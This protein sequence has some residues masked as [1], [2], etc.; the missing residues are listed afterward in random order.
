MDT[1]ITLPDRLRALFVLFVALLISACA[2]RQPAEQP[3]VIHEGV[4]TGGS[5]V[6]FSRSGEMLASG[7]WEGAIHLW[8]MPGGEPA[9]HWQAHRDSVN[10]VAFSADGQ[11][12]VSAGYDKQL[13]AWTVNGKAV[14]RVV[15]PSPVTHMEADPDLD[16]VVTGHSDGSVR[17]W[18]FVDFTLLDE[19]HLHRGSVKAVAI[20]RRSLR[21]ASSGA[22]GRV[23][24]WEEN[25]ETVELQGPP[26]DAWTLAFSPDGKGLFGGTWFR[27]LRWDLGDH[28]LTVLPTEHFG[29]IRSIRFSASGDELATISRQTD[30]SVYFLDPE[31]AEVTRRFQ[32][33][34]L[35]GAAIATSRD[36]R[37][38]ATTSDDASVRIWNL[39]AEDNRRQ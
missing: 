11:Q 28:S 21:Y 33:H 34:E 37:Y 12:L 30:S 24:V 26:A 32:Q 23:H 39:Q 13:V 22:D 31:T 8:Q 19:R 14:R 18:R 38:L 9:G 4:H 29:I 3:T 6:G 25:G 1:T 5:A 27:L 20:D 17:L 16:R 7:G 10:G 35:C 36:G 15:T 2:T